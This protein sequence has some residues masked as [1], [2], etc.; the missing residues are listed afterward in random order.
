MEQ[1]RAEQ[2][3]LGQDR[4]AAVALGHDA[5]AKSPKGAA[6][7]RKTR[8]VLAGLGSHP[9]FPGAYAPGLL[10][11]AFSAQAAKF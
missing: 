3:N 11:R 4:E 8:A 1:R 9:S 7:T 5:E 2:Q 10:H 6:Q